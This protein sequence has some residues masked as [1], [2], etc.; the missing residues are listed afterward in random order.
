MVPYKVNKESYLKKG[1][2]ISKSKLEH[3]LFANMFEFQLNEKYED[4][5]G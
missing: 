1:A 4:N 2:R 5:I 3:K